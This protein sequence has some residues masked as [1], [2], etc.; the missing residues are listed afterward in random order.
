MNNDAIITTAC[1]KVSRILETA[2]AC[3]REMTPQP[4]II[5]LRQKKQRSDRTFTSA[6]LAKLKI[7]N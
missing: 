5:D 3:G 1:A 7:K 6:R 4:R 2:I